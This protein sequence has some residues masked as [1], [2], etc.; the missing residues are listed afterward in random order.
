MT[1]GRVRWLWAKHWFSNIMTLR[2]WFFGA[3]MG[4]LL[5]WLVGTDLGVA[6]TFTITPLIAAIPG[7]VLRCPWCIRIVKGGAKVCPH[8]ASD[9]Q[10]LEYARRCLR[11]QESSAR[12]EEPSSPVSPADIGSYSEYPRK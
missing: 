9:V 6:A 5:G 8:C 2:I 12:S 7:L 1:K 11:E 4:V 10:V 3:G